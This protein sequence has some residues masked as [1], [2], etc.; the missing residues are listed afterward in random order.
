MGALLQTL[1]I[2]CFV[3]FAATFGPRWALLAASV[4]F[5]ALGVAFADVGL[6]QVWQRIRRA[7]IC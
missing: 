6:T 7:W 1:A 4:A 2:T 5:L 3:A